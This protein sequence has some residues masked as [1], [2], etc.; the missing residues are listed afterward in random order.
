[1]PSGS[2]LIIVDQDDVCLRLVGL[3]AGE[4]VVR[5]REVARCRLE[6]RSGLLAV[7][8]SLKPQ[9]FRHLADARADGRRTRTLDLGALAMALDLDDRLQY[10]RS[11]LREVVVVDD[12]VDD[13]VGVDLDPV[14]SLSLAAYV[15][16]QRR[17]VVVRAVALYP[18]VE[19]AR[20]P[21][22]LGGTF[23]DIPAAS[24]RQLEQRLD[25]FVTLSAMA[26][27]FLLMPPSG[28]GVWLG[29]SSVGG[30][31]AWRSMTFSASPTS[32]SSPADGD[33]SETGRV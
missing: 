20:V 17:H 9:R 29:G 1:M 25:G 13:R 14:L 32:G 10:D 3:Y 5:V 16:D 19:R 6:L 30:G 2:S 31:S 24:V 15:R 33:D 18:F 21:T 7:P 26:Q 23:F 11:F 8:A 22:D 4:R 28:F 12:V 27:S